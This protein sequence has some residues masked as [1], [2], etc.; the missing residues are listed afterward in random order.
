MTMNHLEIRNFR[1]AIMIPS[2]AVIT[3]ATL[4]TG[5]IPDVLTCPIQ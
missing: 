1:D 3:S 5:R 4:R 2:G